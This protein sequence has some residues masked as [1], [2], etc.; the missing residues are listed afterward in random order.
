[1]G[2]FDFS[3]NSKSYKITAASLGFF[4]ILVLMIAL[5][6]NW[7]EALQSFFWGEDRIILAKSNGHLNTAGPYLSVFK[8]KTRDGL[9]VEVY[10]DNGSVSEKLAELPLEGTQDGFFNFQNQATNLVLTDVDQDGFVD[11]VA[12]TF[13]EFQQ[14]RLNV[15]RYDKDAAAYV[16]MEKN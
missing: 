7:R 10:K 4:A 8:I 3:G 1:M 15:Y 14:A 12:P 5:I 16:R 11:I 2:M 9:F 13:D 6:P